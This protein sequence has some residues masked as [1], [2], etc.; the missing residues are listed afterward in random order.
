MWSL[1]KA[2]PPQNPQQICSACESGTVRNLNFVIPERDPNCPLVLTYLQ[3]LHCAWLKS[4]V[5][6]SLYFKNI[7]LPWF[8]PEI[9]ACIILLLLPANIYGPFH[10]C[11]SSVQVHCT[12]ACAHSCLLW[13]AGKSFMTSTASSRLWQDGHPGILQGMHIGLHV[14]R[15]PLLALGGWAA[16]GRMQLHPELSK[17]ALS[18][19]LSVAGV[20]LITHCSWLDNPSLFSQK[21]LTVIAKLL[22]IAEAFCGG[23]W[24][25]C[26]PEE[27]DILAVASQH[28]VIGEQPFKKQHSWSC[29]K[30]LRLQGWR[31]CSCLR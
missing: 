15:E 18:Q 11:F 30:V 22:E 14:N 3:F 10:Q 28:S 20:A 7:K 21:I 8:L 26:G 4:G 27:Q 1:H 2:C 6:Q 31:L 24:R 19:E 9:H 17:A 23:G 25:G 12:L 5:G 16:V 13:L 29:D